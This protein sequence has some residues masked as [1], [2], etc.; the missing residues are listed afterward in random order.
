M[1]QKQNQNRKHTQDLSPRAYNNKCKP[2]RTLELNKI[3]F[4]KRKTC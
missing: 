3:F 1:Y 4:K 2:I